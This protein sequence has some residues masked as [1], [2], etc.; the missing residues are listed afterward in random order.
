MRSVVPAQTHLAAEPYVAHFHVGRGVLKWG[1]RNPPSSP[2]SDRKPFWGS[3]VGQYNASNV[4]INCFVGQE[5][6]TNGQGLTTHRFGVENWPPTT[7]D[8]L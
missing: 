4:T 7:K 1:G 6:A 5:L 2:N 8:G 3:K